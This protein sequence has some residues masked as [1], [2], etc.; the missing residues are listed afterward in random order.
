MKRSYT[1]TDTDAL[2]GQ[3]L[4]ALRRRRGETLKETVERAGFGKDAS[5]LAATERGER[6]LTDLEATKLAAHF[7]TTADTIRARPAEILTRPIEW[8]PAT[9]QD[10]LGNTAPTFAEMQATPP[11]PLFAVPD[12]DLLHD[13][14]KLNVFEIDLDAPLTP[15]Q[16]RAEVWIPYL[17]ARYTAETA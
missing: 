1:P 7:N 13:P 12:D 9:E 16:Y 11:T 6:L 3:N 14:V 5:T 10:W 17:E 2:T 8:T 15:E 4:R